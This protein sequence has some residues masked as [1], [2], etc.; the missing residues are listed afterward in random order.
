MLIRL[1]R[2]LLF[3]V[4]LFLPTQLGRHFWPDFSFIYSLK[5]DYLSPTVYFWD[6]LVAVLLVV[7]VLRKP[8]INR[9]ALSLLLF[10]L[11]TQAL[12]LLGA[13]NIGAGLVRLEQYLVAG[14]FGVYLASQD[15]KRLLGKIYLPL[16]L[17]IIGEAAIAILQFIKGGTLG[18][19]ILGE[20]TFTISTPG[21]AKFDFHGLEFLRPYGSFPHPNVL[22]GFMLIVVIVLSLWGS[23]VSRRLQNLNKKDSG[24]A[25]MMLLIAS[26]FLAGLTIFLTMSRTTMAAGFIVILVLI[27]RKWLILMG[28]LILILSP[29]L[30]TRFSSLFNFDNLTLLRREELIGNAWQ[31]FLQHPIFGVGLNNFIQVQASD[32]AIG[33][34]RFLQPVHNI[35]LLTLSES[36]LVGLIGLI[37]LVGYPII[38]ILNF[39]FLIFNLNSNFKFQISNLLPWLI[40]IFLGLFDHYFLTLPQGYR[41]FFLVWGVSLSISR[42]H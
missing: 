11:L 38:R 17:G 26:S 42:L 6:I 7:W 15:F 36:G 40:I 13:D 16:A 30:F 14:F 3:L 28:L 8:G 9:S 5:I 20:R 24:Q 39:K 1:E 22:A 33:P 37:A 34:S 12:S 2:I 35:V 23:G 29:V 25:G 31:I 4:V 18:L 21:I 32:L 10:F 27:R 41:L 19:W